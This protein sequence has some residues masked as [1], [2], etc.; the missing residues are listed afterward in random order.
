MTQLAPT[1][2]ESETITSDSSA[3]AQLNR[4]PFIAC[5][6]MGDASQQVISYNPEDNQDM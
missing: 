3:P 5:G 2:A 4:S 1:T 6:N